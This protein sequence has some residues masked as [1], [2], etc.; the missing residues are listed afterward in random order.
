MKYLYLFLLVVFP[1]VSF[2]QGEY[3]FQFGLF[4]TAEIPLRSQMPKMGTNFGIG[5]QFAYK[6]VNRVPVFLELKGNVGMYD[7]RTSRETFIFDAFSSTETDVTFKSSMNKVQFGTRIYYT[8]FYRP[9]RAYVTPQVGINFLRSRIRIADP[10]DID[11]CRPLENRI[12][13]RS[14]GWTYGGELGVEIDVKQLI[15]GE[16]SNNRLYVSVAY[17]SSFNKVDY[18]NTR[19]MN[20]SEHGVYQDGH[21]YHGGADDRDLTAAFVNVSSNSLHEHKIAEV[22]R[23]PLKFITIHA[24]YIWYF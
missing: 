3:N 11:D 8:S 4:G 22:Y 17:M 20:E 13:H 1:V 12:T 16:Y 6:P 19:Y 9:V 2:S 24:G 15:S 5:L 21:V 10:E 7:Y 18:I 23:T 14:S